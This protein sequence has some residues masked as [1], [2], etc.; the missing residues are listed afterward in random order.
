MPVSKDERRDPF[1]GV[2]PA[3]ELGLTSSLPPGLA[4]RPSQDGKRKVRPSERRRR[5][6]QVSVTFRDAS[7]PD[8]LRD[9]AL[10]WGMMAPDGEKPAVSEL[11]EHLLTP[12]LEAAESGEV[13]P[14]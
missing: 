6:R 3:E 2:E 5:R 4:A 1:A 8:R 7:I 13:K 14:P 11:I 9:L 10:K 12:Q